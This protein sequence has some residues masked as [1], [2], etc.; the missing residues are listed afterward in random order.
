MKEKNTES[1]KKICTVPQCYR[2]L[3]TGTLMT[4]EYKGAPG[5]RFRKPENRVRFPLIDYAPVG[6]RA[7]LMA[8][9]TSKEA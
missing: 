6:I 1:Q 5:L 9:R 3:L 8:R 2:L 7:R 4:I